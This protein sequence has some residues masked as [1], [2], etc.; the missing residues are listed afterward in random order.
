M[1]RSIDLD[2]K[3]YAGVTRYG[4]EAGVPTQGQAGPGVPRYVY[5]HTSC[6][7][8]YLLRIRAGYTRCAYLW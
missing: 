4:Q 7:A 5:I 2:D 8:V 3:R 1:S 6:E